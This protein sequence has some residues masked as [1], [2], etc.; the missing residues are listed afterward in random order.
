MKN[1]NRVP[2]SDIDFSVMIQL[3]GNGDSPGL[4]EH[5]YFFS[6]TSYIYQGRPCINKYMYINKSVKCTLDNSK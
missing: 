5:I 4:F 6:Q 1:Y 3:R 2:K